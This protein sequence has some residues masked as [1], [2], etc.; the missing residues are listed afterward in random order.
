MR[1]LTAAA[2]TCGLLL[3]AAGAAGAHLVARAADPFV[4]VED[5]VALWTFPAERWNNAVLYGFVHTLAALLASRIGLGA[6]RAISA[7]AF[8]TGVILFSGVQITTLLH[9]GLAGHSAVVP[10]DQPP[11]PFDALGPLVPVGGMA[12]MLGWVLLA[13]SAIRTPRAADDQRP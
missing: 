12:F 7:W 3:V 4:S 1:V 2:A 5:A 9:A 11:T 10:G 6:L 13:A 8:L